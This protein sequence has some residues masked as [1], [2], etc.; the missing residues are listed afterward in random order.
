MFYAFLVTHNDSP[1]IHFDALSTFPR[2]ERIAT[3]PYYWRAAVLTAWDLSF[4]SHHYI[5]FMSKVNAYTLRL[6]RMVS[7][8]SKSSFPILSKNTISTRRASHTP[9]NSALGRSS[10]PWKAPFGRTQNNG[11]VAWHD[12]AVTVSEYEL[13]QSCIAFGKDGSVN[14]NDCD[15]YAFDTAKNTRPLRQAVIWQ[16]PC[17]G[18][19]ALLRQR[20]QPPLKAAPD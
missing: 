11:T 2:S 4:P 18:S 10:Q 19:A 6:Y 5:I 7:Y 20:Q 9:A 16:F 1:A 3:N 14:D 12:Y 15:D 17:D 8:V 13:S